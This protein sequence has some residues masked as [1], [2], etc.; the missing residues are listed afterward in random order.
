MI[1]YLDRFYWSNNGPMTDKAC[2]RWYAKRGARGWDKTYL[3]VDEETE[4][5][6]SPEAGKT[7]LSSY[8][9]FIIIIII[10]NDYNDYNFN[11]NIIIIN[12]YKFFIFDLPP[13][14]RIF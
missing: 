5:S 8:S 9:P 2:L 14:D 3:C 10:Y 1:I 11:F 13:R 7:F 6:G 12:S 4:K